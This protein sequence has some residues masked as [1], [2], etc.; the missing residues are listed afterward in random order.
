MFDRPVEDRPVARMCRDASTRITNGS[1]P[2]RRRLKRD[3]RREKP[4]RRGHGRP[5]RSDSLDALDR[6][7]E[8][9][10]P[11][12]LDLER[13]RHEELARLH[14]RWHGV[15]DLGPRATR[16]ANDVQDRLDLIVL[17]SQ[18]DRRIRLLQ[19]AARAL[20]SGRPILVFEEGIDERAGILVVNDRDHEL[21]ARSIGSVESVSGACDGS[22]RPSR[23]VRCGCRPLRR[24]HSGR[25]LNAAGDPSVPDAASQRP[26]PLTAIVA[27]SAALARGADLDDT[28]GSLVGAAVAAV[29][30]ASAA[31]SLQDP[32]RPAPEL[33]FTIGFDEAGQAAL[34]ETVTS[35]DHPLA[36][37]GRDGE[38]ASS[39]DTIALP[40]IIA[41]GGIEQSVGA[42]AFGWAGDHHGEADETT[43][44]RAVADLAAVAVDRDR[45]A[46]TVAE[47]SDWFERLAHTDPLTGLANLRTF[48][49][50]LEL[51]L[52]RAGRQGS[53]VSVAIF[54]VD[55]FAA[56]NEAAGREAGDD[57]LRSVASV[58]AGAVRLVDTVA[59]FGGDE[60]VLV[61]PGSAGMTVARRV[62]DGIAA[63]PAVDGRIISVS[64]GVA[65]FP[66]DGADSGTILAA[67][68]AALENARAQGRGPIEAT[69]A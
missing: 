68:Q 4:R 33:T 29:G 46:S 39:A 25:S 24:R 2:W 34:V 42:I 19:E 26:D 62:L 16:L 6:Q 35:G 69:Q 27:G 18:D 7:D 59:R 51:E 21:H 63:L 45:L 44:L 12:D 64:A 20:E 9:G 28:L 67:A 13:V 54:D 10:C 52:A 66:T 41:R 40:L 30:A 32:D 38:E 50:V 36:T 3:E 57:V 56:T 53:E 17:D 43:F 31:I 55:A 65:R 49:R 61:A 15:D 14:D 5:P 58:L 37:A 48:D 11:S 47:R 1:C 60:F 8:D 23:G 22:G